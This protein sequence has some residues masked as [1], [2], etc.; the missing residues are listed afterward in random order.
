MRLIDADI[1]I[2]MISDEMITDAKALDI[3]RNLGD[4][5]KVETL[6]MAC[7]RHVR[8]IEQLP[9]IERA[10]NHSQIDNVPT[11]IVVPAKHGHWINDKGIYKCTACNNLCTI[12]GWSSSVPEEQMYKVFKFCPDCGA[13]MEAEDG[14]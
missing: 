11:I 12:A 3:F 9:T 5:D 8:M 6:N 7:K 13:K 14:N 2:K 4:I 10:V 1:A